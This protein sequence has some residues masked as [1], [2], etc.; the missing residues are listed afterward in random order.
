MK[1]GAIFHSAEEP[2]EEP[3]SLFY[4]GKGFE[5]IRL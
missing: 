1:G 4:A 2:C 3:R 5:K